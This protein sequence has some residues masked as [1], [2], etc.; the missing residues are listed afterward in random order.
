MKNASAGYFCLFDHK[1]SKLFRFAGPVRAGCPALQQFCTGTPGV[2]TSVR[3]GEL[4]KGG[5]RVA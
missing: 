1:S 2:D 3:P 4:K 5:G